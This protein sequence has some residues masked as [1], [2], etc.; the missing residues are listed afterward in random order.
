M[1]Q[2]F[3]AIFELYNMKWLSLFP[4]VF[5][6][7][8]TWGHLVK[9]L[10][11]QVVLKGVIYYFWLDICFK[12]QPSIIKR[13]A[14]H[15]RCLCLCCCLDPTAR[16]ITSTAFHLLSLSSSSLV[17]P[18]L[19]VSIASLS[20]VHAHVLS[21]SH[22]PRVQNLS[23]RHHIEFGVRVDMKTH[24]V[25]D[26]LPI[27]LLILIWAWSTPRLCDLTSDFHSNVEITGVSTTDSV[28]CYCWS[29]LPYVCRRR[30]IP[31]WTDDFL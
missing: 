19:T 18:L 11:C 1:I 13:C 29:G 28:L 8:F 12:W 30:F 10:L 15:Q 16:Y 7:G 26:G 21:V 6:W 27:S 25:K 20:T 9:T 23:D 22:I 24:L 14:V 31:M 3:V 5:A 17:K 4:V 2:P